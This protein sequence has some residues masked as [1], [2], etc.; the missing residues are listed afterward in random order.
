MEAFEKGRID[1]AMVGAGESATLVQQIKRVADIIDD[2]VTGFWRE[3]ERL[4]GLL[5]PTT[6]Q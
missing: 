4:A 6:P 5:K 1:L 3:I 2:T